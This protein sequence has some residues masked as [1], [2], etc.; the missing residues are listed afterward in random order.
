MFW[1]C[2]CSYVVFWYKI[3]FTVEVHCNTKRTNLYVLLSKWISYQITLERVMRGSRPLVNTDQNTTVSI[4]RILPPFYQWKSCYMTI[5]WCAN[6]FIVMKLR[7]YLCLWSFLTQKIPHKEYLE[8]ILHLDAGTQ[9]SHKWKR[10]VISA[11]L[12]ETAGP[13]PLNP[14]VQE[15]IIF[16]WLCFMDQWAEKTNLRINSTRLEVLKLID[17][18]SKVHGPYVAF[19]FIE[20]LY[21]SAI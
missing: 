12:V 11:F 6:P 4:Q 14:L 5:S 18:E 7:V 3:F 17:A 10:K 15:L 19:F 1:V 20:H 16:R 2:V 8:S 13:S 21:L 9:H